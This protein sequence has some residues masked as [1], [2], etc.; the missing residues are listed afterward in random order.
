M[1]ELP[2]LGLQKSIDKIGFVCTG[3]TRHNK[4]ISRHYG[5]VCGIRTTSP[6]RPGRVFVEASE[7]GPFV[8]QA[9]VK[10]PFNNAGLYRHRSDLDGQDP[11]AAVGCAKEAADLHAVI[12]GVGGL[13]IETTSVGTGRP[14]DI[15]IV[16]GPLV[17]QGPRA[18]GGHAEGRV[19]AIGDVRARRLEA[20]NARQ[21]RGQTGDV[22]RK[23]RRILTSVQVERR[24]A[25]RLRPGATVIGKMALMAA[26]P[27]ALIVTFVDPR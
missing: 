25:D 23:F 21:L 7:S 17:A 11:R 10:R 2:V 26:L 1:P 14:G 19:R 3:G 13:D 8:G 15:G 20:D 16:E 22:L 6:A 4:L 9:I 24:N 5:R 27:L 18:R 12:A